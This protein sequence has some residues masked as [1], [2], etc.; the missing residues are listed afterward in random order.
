MAT[1]E[2]DLLRQSDLKRN[3]NANANNYNGEKGHGTN[4]GDDAAA[5][6]RTTASANDRIVNVTNIVKEKTTTDTTTTTTT[7]T[8]NAKHTNTNTTTTN[9][10]TTPPQHKMTATGYYTP[11][12]FYERNGLSRPEHLDFTKLDRVIYSS[13]R[14]EEGGTI[15]GMVRLVSY[16][17]CVELCVYVCMCDLLCFAL[18]CF[19]LI[20]FAL[21]HQEVSELQLCLWNNCQY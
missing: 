12:K 19:V 4:G 6:T 11:S 1:S 14:V 13:F 15:S 16:G 7:T 9:N 18:I 10:S 20:C 17:E 8:T 2:L 21:L 3:T 5:T